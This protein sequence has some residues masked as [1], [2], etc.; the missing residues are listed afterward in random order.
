MTHL[1]DNELSL[2]CPGA[3][4]KRNKSFQGVMSP[5][6]QQGMDSTLRLSPPGLTRLTTVWLPARQE[7]SLNT[8][9]GFPADGI[10]GASQGFPTTR[11]AT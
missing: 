9:P 8:E 2:S 7:C 11:G 6:K 10:S 5:P 3:T 4:A 1:S